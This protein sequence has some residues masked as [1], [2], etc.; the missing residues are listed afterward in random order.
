MSFALFLKDKVKLPGNDYENN[1]K[2]I[3]HLKNIYHR[4]WYNKKEH[5]YKF[6]LFICYYMCEIQKVV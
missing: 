6:I 1:S 5:F 3:S 4:F 2:Y